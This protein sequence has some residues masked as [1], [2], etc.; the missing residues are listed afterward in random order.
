[1]SLKAPP[2]ILKTVMRSSTSK[3][4]SS[5]TS[6]SVQQFRAIANSMKQSRIHD[7]RLLTI[8][9]NVSKNLE[10]LRLFDQKVDY[11]EECAAVNLKN[12]VQMVKHTLKLGQFV[13]NGFK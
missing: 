3:D 9:E 12:A 2:Q 8:F 11:F 4:N 7:P 6:A 1:M 10:I 5:N 13:R